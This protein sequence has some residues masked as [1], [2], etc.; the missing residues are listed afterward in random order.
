MEGS[1]NNLILQ[2]KNNRAQGNVEEKIK[3]NL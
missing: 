1:K 3:M 2:I